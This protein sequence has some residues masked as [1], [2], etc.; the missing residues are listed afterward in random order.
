MMDLA[1]VHH[2]RY[3]RIELRDRTVELADENVLRPVGVRQL[4]QDHLVIVEGA[5]GTAVVEAKALRLARELLV[6]AKGFPS[7][8]DVVSAARAIGRG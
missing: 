7:L 2:R 4:L 3:A 8:A 1:Y 6:D 5:A